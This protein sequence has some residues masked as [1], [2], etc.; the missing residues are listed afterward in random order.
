MMHRKARIYVQNENNITLRL[1]TVGIHIFRS[2]AVFLVALLMLQHV[3][4][5]VV[6]SIN[7]ICRDSRSCMKKD[8]PLEKSKVKL[9]MLQCRSDEKDDVP[10]SAYIPLDDV[11]LY[12]QPII[13]DPEFPST[14]NDDT[15]SFTSTSSLTDFWSS[16]LVV[17][18]LAT[19]LIAF[20][21]FEI[22]AK[23]F[24]N[25]NDFL[26]QGNKWVAVDG[27][28]Y[29]ARIIAPAINGLVV[30]AVALLFATLISTTITTLRQRQVEI[31]RAINME[32]GELRAM[33]CLFD[34]IDPGFIQDQCRSYV[35]LIFFVITFR[36][37]TNS[38]K[39]I[40]SFQ[41]VVNSVYKSDHV[42]MPSQFRFWCGCDQPSTWF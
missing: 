3:S 8:V 33:E 1:F 2:I 28:A 25:F 20:F 36:T 16:L 31:R 29:Q 13:C 17:V 32:A 22:C 12:D 38:K 42:G 4:S 30:P 14:S 5:F 19:P 10:A 24:S 7:E 23:A 35:C 34:A 40:S 26:S 39:L 27:G 6:V 9:S 21:T 11:L 41:N 15:E 18:P 37:G